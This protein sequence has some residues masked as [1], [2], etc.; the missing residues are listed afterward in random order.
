MAGTNLYIPKGTTVVIPVMAIHHDPN[1]YPDPEK[2]NPD[3][4]AAEEMSKR[5]SIA[6]LP[7]GEGPRNCIGLRFGMM[8]ARIGLATV[9]LNYKLSLS[10]NMSIPLTLAKNQSIIASEGGIRLRLERLLI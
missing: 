4:F 9:L 3:R 7:F 10:P 1:I 5:N 2:F 6:F 8:Q